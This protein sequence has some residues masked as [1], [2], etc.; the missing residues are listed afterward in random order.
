MMMNKYNKCACCNNPW[1]Q[2]SLEG[3]VSSSFA[4]TCGDCTTV[5]GI[6]TNNFD[7]SINPKDNFYLWSNGGWKA[8][9][10]IPG[11]YSSWNTFIELRD[12]NLDRL[13]KIVDDLQNGSTEGSTQN[14]Q[15]LSVFFKAM[16]DEKYIESRGISPLLPIIDLCKTFRVGHCCHL[17]DVVSV[18]RLLLLAIFIIQG[19]S[20]AVIAALHGEYGISALFSLHSSPVSNHMSIPQID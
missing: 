17:I 12:L 11:E 7:H 10:P 3:A 19:N 6:D 15:K 20:T 14:S 8:D 1:N 13:K 2:S 4:M 5:P 16:M 9:N 18:I